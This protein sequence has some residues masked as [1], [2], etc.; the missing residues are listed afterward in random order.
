MR[1]AAKAGEVRESRFHGITVDYGPRV[2]RVQ[3]DAAL[4]RYLDGHRRRALALARHMRG[5]Y[6][7]L[8]GRELDIAEDSLAIEVVAH[9]YAE[10]LAEGIIRWAERLP[11][12][13]ENAVRGLMERVTRSAEVID[14][15]EAAID[16][17]RRI[18]DALVPL[19]RWI[20]GE[21]EARES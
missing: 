3:A 9:L 20:L 19:K 15:G 18:W 14:C 6:R 4:E 21:A 16:T 5:R 1:E 2:V 8:M 7:V 17:N 10:D 13:P 11:Q 12:G